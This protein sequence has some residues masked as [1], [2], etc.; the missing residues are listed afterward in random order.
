MAESVPSLDVAFHLVLVAEP[1]VIFTGTFLTSGR[2]P[3][4][5]SV[6]LLHWRTKGV[7]EPQLSDTY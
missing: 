4:A 5:R 6:G 3:D 7:S 1:K 2:R